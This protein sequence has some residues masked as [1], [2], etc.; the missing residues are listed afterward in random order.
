MGRRR[1]CWEGIWSQSLARVRA[2]GLLL[3]AL[4]ALLRLL[5]TVPAA[6]VVHNA[7]HVVARS[8]EAR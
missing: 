3:L 1:S 4:I 2:L 5:A 6:A 7:L 8:G